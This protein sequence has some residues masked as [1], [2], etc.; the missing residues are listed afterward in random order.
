MTVWAERATAKEN[1]AP[2]KAWKGDDSLK[3]IEQ[4]KLRE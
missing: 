2:A 3:I 4:W 1:P